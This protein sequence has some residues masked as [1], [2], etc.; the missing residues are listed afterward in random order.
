M[1]E[2]I[3]VIVV[4]GVLSAVAIVK[5]SNLALNAGM[6]RN[7]KLIFDTVDFI[8]AVYSN[9]V[10]LEKKPVNSLKLEDLMTFMSKD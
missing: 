5:F 9:L 4:I 2:L 1:I 10:D 6:N 3:F 7:F 8:P